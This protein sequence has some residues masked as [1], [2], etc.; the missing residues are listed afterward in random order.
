[1]LL[2]D[3]AKCLSSSRIASDSEEIGP[4]SNMRRRLIEHFFF[5]HDQAIRQQHAHARTPA[6]V[7]IRYGCIGWD[8]WGD[9]DA[10]G[11]VGAGG[12]EQRLPHRTS[13]L[14]HQREGELAKG[15]FQV[16]R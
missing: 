7:R 15:K 9:S 3:T 13:I 6:Y 10:A 16:K 1:M 12:E 11:V 14:R 5:L 2:A 4:T 8:T